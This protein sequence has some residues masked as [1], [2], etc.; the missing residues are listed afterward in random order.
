MKPAVLKMWQDPKEWSN[1]LDQYADANSH[2]DLEH[3]RK[4]MEL[5]KAMY[6]KRAVETEVVKLHRLA[7]AE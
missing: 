2:S 4:R 1:R 3:F 6:G 7:R 5:R